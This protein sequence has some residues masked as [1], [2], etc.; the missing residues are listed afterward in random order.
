MIPSAFDYFAP[1]SLDEALTL[2]ARHGPEA[3]LLAGGH[4]LLPMMKLRLAAPRVVIDLGRVPGLAYIREEG[5]RIV[6]GA[7]ATHADIEHSELLKRRAPLL[8]ETAAEIGDVQVRNCGTLGGTAAHA[9]PAAD[10]PAALLALDAEFVLA[11]RQGARTV[12]A[13]DFFVDML[14]TALVPGEILTEVR[15]AADGARTGS[16]YRKL[17]QPASGFAI[18]GVATR[19]TLDAGGRC[20]GVAVGITGV[21]PKAYR[22]TGVERGL[23]GQSLDSKRIAE[24]AAQAARGVEPLADLHASAR[25]RAA[26]AT[27]FT[28]RA[29]A[30]ALERAQK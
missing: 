20:A 28:R 12:A 3:K 13:S 16:A 4:S 25:Y 15:F 11:S 21:A 6:I 1:R 19:V 29:L 8:A 10:Y 18:V 17:H 5:G 26:M 27:V 14:T 22:A 9:D 7:M 24:A 30:A 23:G 2:L